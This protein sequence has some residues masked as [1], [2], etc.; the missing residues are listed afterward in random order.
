[1]VVVESG[2]SEKRI[3]LENADLNELKVAQVH[4]GKIRL[5]F[6]DGRA[7]GVFERQVCVAEILCNDFI[8]AR[9]TNGELYFTE[10]LKTAEIVLDRE[11]SSGRTRAVLK[12]YY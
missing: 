9:I 7:E 8:T 11:E 6:N 10:P 5:L 4:P 12:F 2:V 1:M 3:Q